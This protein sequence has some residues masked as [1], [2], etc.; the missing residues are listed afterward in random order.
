MNATARHDAKATSRGRPPRSSPTTPRALTALVVSALILTACGS[1]HSP[2]SGKGTTGGETRAITLVGAYGEVTVPVTDEDVWAL[3]P[4][5]ATELLAL[6]VTPTHAGTHTFDGDAAYEARE[7]VLAD[8]GVEL[9]EP[10]NLELIVQ[11]RPALIVGSRS[12][13]SDELI[14]ALER[15]AP[16]LITA[17]SS[18]WDEG[19][20]LLGRAT[21]RDSEAEAIIAYLDRE[22][23]TTRADIERAG[24]HGETV[25]LM[26]PCGAGTFCAYG[27]GRTAGP[28]LTDLGFTR[29]SP[30]GQDR[31]DTE[32]GY[33]TVSEETL[34]DLVAPIIFVLLG[35]VQLDAPDPL[36]NPL[37]EVGDA[38][39]GEVDFG[40]WF[41]AGSFDVPWI[42]N[43]VR[44]VLLDDG[45]VTDE[46]RG[47]ALFGE[48]EKVAS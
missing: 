44:A 46:Q 41:G 30:H 27:S 25:S 24:L 9:V 39:V 35:S 23:A 37:F 16:V 48:L 36:S 22:I 4:A 14:D 33:T 11:A 17:A 29:P 40:A 15:I 18:R 43:D 6:G 26:S 8:G 2:D 7:Q 19:L 38:T 47:M 42:L 45:A 13:A 21:G 28:I 20:E 5:A 10:G 34:G 31:A 1:G 12:P 3:D 32:W